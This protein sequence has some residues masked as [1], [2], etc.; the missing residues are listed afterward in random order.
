MA[1]SIKDTITVVSAT[2]AKSPKVVPF[3]RGKPGVGKS[4]AAL[5]AGKK[6]GIPDERTLVVHINNHD[7]VDFTGVPSVVESQT[8]FNPTAM[9]YKFREGTGP[10]LIVLEELA[11]S[12]VHHQTWAAGFIYERE[13]STFKLDPQVRIIATGNR[14]EDRAGARPLLS[15][16]AARMY[17]IDVES[18]L[19]SW[20]EWALENGV[21]PTGV[22][23]LR[24]RPALLNQFD[25]TATASPTE[26]SWTQLLTEIPDSLPTQ[27][28]MEIAA[29]KVG[30]GAAT[31][32]V[33]ARDIMASMPNISEIRRDPDSVKVPSRIEVQFA[34]AT[35]LSAT[36]TRATFAAE[37]A[38]MSKLPAEM[39]VLYMK[40]K[41][42]MTPEIQA[43]AAFTRWTLENGKLLGAR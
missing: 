9:F 25:P 10:G 40:D 22:A 15:H 43:E 14:V 4:A 18:D 34:V 36:G 32:W 13:T 33:A 12:S 23:F 31:E 41:I 37:V 1:L 30:E 27:L 42:R 24:F 19:D 3:L 26:R 28:Y 29:G 38:Y 8:V 7:V 39:Q 35:A 20:V 6:L 16:L 17:D 21:P 11:Q 2:L 5:A